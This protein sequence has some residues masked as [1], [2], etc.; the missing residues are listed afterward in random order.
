MRGSTIP[1]IDDLTEQIAKISNT[2]ATLKNSCDQTPT[3]VLQPT[4]TPKEE[5][6]TLKEETPTPIARDHQETPTPKEETPTPIAQDQ[7]TP[8]PKRRN[9]DCQDHQQKKHQSVV[10]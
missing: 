6:P 2:L 9:S 4:P 3:P 8:T 1:V 10:K 7:E 5:T